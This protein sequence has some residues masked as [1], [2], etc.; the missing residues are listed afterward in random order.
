[1][2]SFFIPAHTVQAFQQPVTCFTILAIP[3]LRLDWL[4]PGFHP[5]LLWSKV[6]LLDILPV[7]TT[8]QH[9]Y[10]IPIPLTNIVSDYLHTVQQTTLVRNFYGELGCAPDPRLPMCRVHGLD[11]DMSDLSPSFS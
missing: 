3:L 10:D 6:T 2:N 8:R 1:M 9:V 11:I 5:H 7:S 4:E